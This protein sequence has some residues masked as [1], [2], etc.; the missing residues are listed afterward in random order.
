VSAVA[1][2]MQAARAERAL[3]LDR[4]GV[5]IVVVGC[6]KMLAGEAQR[7]AAVEL[8]ATLVN[9]ASDPSITRVTAACQGASAALE[10]RDPTTGKSL[11]R[12]VAL[13]ATAPNAR[14]RLLALAVAEL[15]A[16]SWSELESNPQPRAPPAEPLA[17][18]AAREAARAAVAGR[19][20]ELAAVVD[21]HLLASGDGLVG[22]GA[23][24]AFWLS[25]VV[26]LRVDVLANYAELGRTAGSVAV[27]MPS[28]S[29]AIG[30]AGWL[31]ARLRPAVSAGI[32]SGYVWMNGVAA[33]TAATGSRQQGPWIGPEISLQ[34]TAW[35][36]A[37]FHPVLGVTAGAHLVGVRGTV[38][39]DRDVQ[40]MGFWG[41]LSAA[42]ALR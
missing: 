3:G 4:P 1:I 6:D 18:Q 16:A 21:L 10:V 28:A 9:A 11:Q 14:A 39:A 23:R 2:V 40:A 5:S 8:R 30:A 22:G 7:I 33:G 34:I 41:G 32:R 29:F 35:P 26:F 27:V 38:D 19:S 13:T 17:P 42:V 15:V 25:P 20:V 12:T 37:R 24:A 31:G 36:S